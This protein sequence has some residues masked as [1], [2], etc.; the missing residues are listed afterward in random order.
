MSTSKPKIKVQDVLELL[1]KGYTRYEK[2]NKG[3]GSIQTHYGLTGVQ[4]KELFLHSKLKQRKTILPKSSLEII[5]EEEL[6]EVEET[7]V[8]EPQELPEPTPEKD[9]LVETGLITPEVKKEELFS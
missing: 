8:I 3:Y 2:D 1:K 9:V 5:D 4:V 6:V 7:E